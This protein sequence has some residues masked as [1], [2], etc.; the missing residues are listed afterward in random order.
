[1]M[2][3]IFY[4]IVAT[5]IDCSLAVGQLADPKAGPIAMTCFTS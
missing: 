3:S 5:E 4:P 2:K 1:M